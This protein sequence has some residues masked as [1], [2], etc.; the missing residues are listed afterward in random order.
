[1]AKPRPGW[2]PSK[3]FQKGVVQNPRG[4]GAGS[5][6]KY[7][8]NVWQL[9]AQRG[10]RDPLDVISEFASSNTVDPNLKLQAAGML[11]SYKHGKRPSYRYIEDV[12]GMK[13]PT[14]IE[15]ALQYQARV[16]ELVATGKLDIDGATAL[17]DLLQG[18]IEGKVACDLERRMQQAEELLRVMEARGIGSVGVRVIGGLPELPGT[19]ITM[20]AG[21]G[22]PTIENAPTTAAKPGNV[23]SNPWAT[24]DVGA[25]VKVKPG[26]NKRSKTRRKWSDPLPEPGTNPKGMHDPLG[27]G[28]NAPGPADDDPGE[29]S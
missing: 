18:Y 9:I 23:P 14:T 29:A 3:P 11:A 2:K 21:G 27:L 26:A 20:P 12:V 5:R 16:A 1:M 8:R 28:D 15:E 17:K 25:Q 7:A 10:D 22:P 4:R 24:P 6:G 19:M 13:A